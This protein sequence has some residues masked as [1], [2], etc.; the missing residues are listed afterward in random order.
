MRRHQV[1]YGQQKHR[2]APRNFGAL[3]DNNT[4][5]VIRMAPMFYNNRSLLFD[6]DID[7]L[8]NTEFYSNHDL[9]N[10]DLRSFWA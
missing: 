6:M 3:I 7:Q 4:M 5:S 8:K 1:V 9:V 10:Y 2:Q